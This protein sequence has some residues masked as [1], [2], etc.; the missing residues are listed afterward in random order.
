MEHVL[1]IRGLVHRYGDHTALAGVDLTVKAGSV[2]H[3]SAQTGPA[4][5]PSS[6]M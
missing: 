3:C 4:R 6:A 1:E 2:S 5:R